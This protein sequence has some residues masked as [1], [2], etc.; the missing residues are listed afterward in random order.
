M[1]SQNSFTTIK[2]KNYFN[3]IHH[4]LFN[5]QSIKLSSSSEIDNVIQEGE[6]I[7]KK[8][9]TVGLP[10]VSRLINSAISKRQGDQRNHSFLEKNKY[11]IKGKMDS[12]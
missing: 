12:L 7:F 5:N 8:N 11:C 6:V 3:K 10:E 9:P 4:Q 2:R 1:P